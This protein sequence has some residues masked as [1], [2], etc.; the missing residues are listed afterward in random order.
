M[1]ALDV[2]G[3][4]RERERLICGV[5][6]NL[7]GFSIQE[8]DAWNG[9]YVDFC[10]AIAAAVLGNPGAVQFRVVA[11]T[12]RFA[13]V[14]RNDVD[15]L[16]LP[17]PYSLT[18]DAI[19]HIGFAPPIFHD[20]QAVMVRQPKPSKPTPKAPAQR[21]IQRLA[22]L[23]KRSICVESGISSRVLQSYLTQAKVAASLQTAPDLAAVLNQ[24][25]KG[26]CDAISADLSQL[27]AWRSRQPQKQEHTL[28]PDRLSWEPLSPVVHSG[29]DRWR[30][31]ITWVVFSTIRAE[32]LGI[33]RQNHGALRSRPDPEVGRFLGTQDSLGIELGLDPDWTTQILDSVGNYGEI[34]ERHLTPL[35]IPRAENRLRRNGGRME[36]MPFR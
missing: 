9:F 33:T 35:G 16:L 18:R 17:T 6:A 11:P 21:P 14:Q 29:D 24:Y 23:N 15:V 25:E 32:E 36:S 3:R 2:L 8:G 26:T 28:L 5:S 12:D 34:F 20:H 10:R 7:P 1:P 19:P 27:L 30:T 31:I 4:V 13:A 22:D